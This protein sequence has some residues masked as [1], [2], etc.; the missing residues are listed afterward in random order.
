MV[1]DLPSLLQAYY[2]YRKGKRNCVYVSEFENTLENKLY[3]LHQELLNR[4]YTIGKSQCFV[5]TYPTT[6]EIFAAS[7][8]DRI[9][10]HLLINHIEKHI[11]KKFIYDSLACRKN[12]GSL[13]GIRR[14]RRFINKITHNH[15]KQAYYLK[16]DIDSFF[17][18]ID[19]EILSRI[20]KR[21]IRNLN[22]SQKDKEDLIWLSSEIIFH[23][24]CSNYRKK[25]SFKIIGSLPKNKSL[26]TV[27]K[28]K[29]LAIGNLTSQFFANLYLNEVDQYIKRKLKVKYYLRYADDMLF[30]SESIDT[31]EIIE[32]K[33][34]IFL[35]KNLR[36]KIKRN[37][38]VYGSVYQGIDFVGYIVKPRYTLCRNRVLANLKRKLYYFNEGYL[39][40]RKLCIERRIPLGKNI[41]QKDVEALC[42]SINS[43]FGHLKWSNSYLLRNNLYNKYFGKLKEYIEPQ[44]NLL[45]FRPSKP[46]V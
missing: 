40:N 26:F 12:K 46:T 9:V 41:T 2:S 34:G 6:R 29:G 33:V 38:T 19:K 37:K 1:F 15:T 11:D 30:L 35:Y 43:T 21:E 45:S 7:F 31:L 42:A 16:L 8:R 23:N 18:S 24:P 17:Y 13:L 27:P 39:I 5:I 10:H 32:R 3:L 4:S 36:L 22:F 14:L 44:N 25:G 20:L 28:G